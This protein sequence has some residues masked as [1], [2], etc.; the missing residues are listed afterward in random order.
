MVNLD[1]YVSPD[2]QQFND[3]WYRYEGEFF[4]N[5]K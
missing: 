2:Y 1:K 5:K 3:G 4:E